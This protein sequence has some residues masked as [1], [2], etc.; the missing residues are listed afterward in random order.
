[1]SVVMLSLFASV[2]IKGKKEKQFIAGI[3]NKT[4]AVVNDD[5]AALRLP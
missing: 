5:L 2:I 3:I 4:D 1:M